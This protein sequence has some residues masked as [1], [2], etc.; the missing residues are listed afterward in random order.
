MD[1]YP[2]DPIFDL[3]VAEHQIR[4]IAPGSLWWVSEAI[5]RTA[6]HSARNAWHSSGKLSH[7]CAILGS[8]GGCYDLNFV[9]LTPGRT[10][11]KHVTCPEGDE[12]FVEMRPQ[13][14]PGKITKF[15]GN[16]GFIG[17]YRLECLLDCIRSKMPQPPSVGRWLHRNH[18]V[19]Q[20]HAYE[21]ATLTAWAK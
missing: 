6:T 16:R 8:S 4:Q 15:G 2:A 14:R 11:P 10:P 19:P 12:V 1:S 5:W 18:Q 21:F 13:T 9:W 3:A 7:P 20:L 17:L